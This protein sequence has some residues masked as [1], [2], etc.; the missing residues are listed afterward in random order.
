PAMRRLRRMIPVKTDGTP[1]ERPLVRAE[2]ELVRRYVPD[3]RV[4]H[5]LLFGRLDRFI[6]DSF[7]YERTPLM[8]RALMNGIEPVDYPL[9]SLPPLTRL[10]GACV[11]YGHPAKEAR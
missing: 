9:L 8:R 4:R 10:G 5:Y 7:N 2:V 1:G 3:C 6:L 11:M